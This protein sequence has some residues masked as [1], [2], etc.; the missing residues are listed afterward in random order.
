MKCSREE[1]IGLTGEVLLRAKAHCLTGTEANT[2]AAA[3]EKRALLRGGPA[4]RQEARLPNLS[5]GSRVH[6]EI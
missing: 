1:K 2:T 6:G 3:F 4:R 5:P